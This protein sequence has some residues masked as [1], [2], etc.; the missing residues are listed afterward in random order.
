MGEATFKAFIAQAKNAI[1]ID[2]RD[3]A[4]LQLE[5]VETEVLNF[6]PVVGARRKVL[7]VTITWD[8]NGG[9]IE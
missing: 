9:E 5:T 2:G 8:D 3:G 6:L 4:H 1:V 7:D